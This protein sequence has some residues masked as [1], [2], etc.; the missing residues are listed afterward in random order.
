MFEMRPFKQPDL[1][2]ISVGGKCEAVNAHGEWAPAVLDAISKSGTYWVAFQSS[3]GLS[4]SVAEVEGWALRPTMEAVEK[5]RE[6]LKMSGKKRERMQQEAEDQAQIG[7]WK[8]FQSKAMKEG[9]I[10]GPAKFARR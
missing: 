2:L 7:S 5:K 4:S 3:K 9:K 10:G 1:T 6:E 8:A